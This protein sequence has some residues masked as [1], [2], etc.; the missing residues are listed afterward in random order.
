MRALILYT[1]Y[2][3]QTKAIASYIS[4]IL[5]ATTECD[6]RDLSSSMDIN[7]IQYTSVMIGS[8]VR[9]G[10]FH[11]AL[12]EFIR[13]NLRQLNN[14]QS[15]FFAVNLV[16]RKPQHR[17]PQSNTY[18]KK[19]LL[20]TPWRPKQCSVFAGALR[21]PRYSWLDR[22]IIKLIMKITNG[23]TDTTKEVEYTDWQDVRRAALQFSCLT[24]EF[25]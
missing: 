15:A 5:I 9:Y 10:H 20:A 25:M 4:S 16:A 13:L 23:E 22:T 3:G 1:S 21:Y 11:R 12:Y 18:T 7:L 8:S 19:F 24:R 2:Y 14:M 17:T 6:L